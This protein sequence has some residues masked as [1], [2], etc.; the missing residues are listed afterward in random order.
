MVARPRG[1]DDA[2]ED[3]RSAPELLGEVVEELGVMSIT[4]AT[5]PP[6]LA[7]PYL[8]RPAE[9]PMDAFGELAVAGQPPEVEALEIDRVAEGVL[10]DPTAATSRASAVVGAAVD[11][12][13]RRPA[14]VGGRQIDHHPFE[15]RESLAEFGM[16]PDVVSEGLAAPPN[17]GV[18]GAA[19]HSFALLEEAWGGVERMM[20]VRPPIEEREVRPTVGRRGEREHEDQQ[21]EGQT[22]HDVLWGRARE[23]K[24]SLASEKVAV[25][26]KVPPAGPIRLPLS[27]FRY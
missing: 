26:P 8:E 11:H 15:A 23:H 3:V 1:A 6:V 16:D 20:V 18:S 22:D 17:Q 21:D 12:P 4:L 14:V 27:C 25:E 13:P 5:R 9:T 10:A 7:D 19:I 24:G 2:A